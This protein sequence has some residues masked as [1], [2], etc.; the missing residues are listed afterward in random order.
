MMELPTITASR[1]AELA[2]NFAQTLAGKLE[3]I[4]RKYPAAVLDPEFQ[5]IVAQAHAG[6][7]PGPPPAELIP[8]FEQLFYAYM[9]SRFVIIPD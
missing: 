5:D 1:L 8:V 7:L 9:A 3:D 2:S 6:T 4:N